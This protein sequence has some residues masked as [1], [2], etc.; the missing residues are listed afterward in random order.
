MA[1]ETEV[2][3]SKSVRAEPGGAAP[4][5]TICSRRSALVNVPVFSRKAEAGRITSANLVV[6]VSK[7][8]WQTRKSSD[9]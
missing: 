1:L 7:M 2:M 5:S 6:S 9:D 4:G 3:M 8:S